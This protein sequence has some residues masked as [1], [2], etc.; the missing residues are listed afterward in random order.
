VQTGVWVFGIR[1]MLDATSL[2]NNTTFSTIP[3]SGTADS[4]TRWFDTLT[5][6]FG[7]N[8]AT[9]HSGIAARESQRRSKNKACPPRS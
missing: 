4:R 2:S 8:H 6:R 5:A 3:F 1:N 9:G 7:A